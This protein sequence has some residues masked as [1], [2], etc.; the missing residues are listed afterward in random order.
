MG[1]E[2]A[3]IESAVSKYAQKLGWLVYKFQSPNHRGV[4]DRILLRKG[5]TLF[6]EFK[7]LTGKASRL[8]EICHEALIDQGFKVLI[9]DNI[10]AGKKALDEMENQDG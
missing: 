6:I 10:E 3:K 1:K 7:T 8:Q 2:E 4:P 9:I 5:V